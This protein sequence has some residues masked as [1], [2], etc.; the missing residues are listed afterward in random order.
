MQ[1]TKNL[2]RVSEVCKYYSD[3]HLLDDFDSMYKLYLQKKITKQIT[4]IVLGA[5]QLC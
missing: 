5:F 3:M 1:L 2:T 4:S